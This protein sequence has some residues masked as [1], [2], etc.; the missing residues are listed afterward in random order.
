MICPQ[1]YLCK[2][3]ASPFVHS[4]AA[5]PRIIGR[6]EIEERKAFDTSAHVEDVALN[7]LNATSFSALGAV[8]IELH[9]IERG[10]GFRQ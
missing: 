8:G 2:I 3:T 10:I 7:G 6:V 4:R 1:I 5:P 9:P